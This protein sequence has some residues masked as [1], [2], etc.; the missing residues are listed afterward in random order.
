VAMDVSFISATLVLPAVIAA[1]FPASPDERK[2][3]TIIVLVKPQFEAGRK[4]VGKGGLVRDEDAQSGAVQRVRSAVLSLGAAQ[5]DVIESPILGMEG[6]R[7]FL[8][9]GLF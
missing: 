7:E 6:N 4:H 3:R 1:A 8:L 2:G 9:R 5:T